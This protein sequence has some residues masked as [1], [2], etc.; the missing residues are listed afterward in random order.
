MEWRTINFFKLIVLPHLIWLLMTLEIM[1]QA[2]GDTNKQNQ[3]GM[4]SMKAD[5]R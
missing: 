4:L 3:I 2:A 1:T 5:R